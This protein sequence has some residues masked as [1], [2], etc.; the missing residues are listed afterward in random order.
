[1]KSLLVVVPSLFIS[2]V[3]LAAPHVDAQGN[4]IRDENSCGTTRVRVANDQAPVPYH[5][6]PRVIYLNKNGGTYNVVNSAT[7]S[8]TNTASTITS[9]DGAQHM[10]A[11]IPPIEA[12]YNWPYIVDCVKKQYKPYNVIITETE[13]TSGN[14]IEAVVGGNGRSTGWSSSSGI[15]GVASADNFCG[16]TEKGIA[17]SFSTNHLGITKPND[18]LCATIAHEVGH[19]VALEHEISGPD[20][21][22][23]VSFAQAGSKSFT[24]AD[25]HCGTD[26]SNQISCSC[27]P[28]APGNL[29]SSGKRLTMF[30]GARP[31]ETVPPTL[32]VSDPT[33]NKTLR[34]KFSILATAMDETAMDQVA[35]RIDGAV[36]GASTT[37]TDGT[38]YTITLSNV[39]EGPHMLDVEAVDLAGN[40]TKKQLTITVAKGKPGEDCTA[41]EDCQGNLCAV[42]ED[43]DSFCTQ[44]CDA[45]NKCPSGFSCDEAAMFC[46]PSDGG[47]CSVGG[48]PAGFAIILGL[49]LVLVPRR[50]K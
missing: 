28:T 48:G 21:M 30:L 8:A 15:L 39:P 11:V 23:Y 19:L 24:S 49:M 6:A 22:S 4:L 33:N 29:T 36:M 31:M 43:G 47:G 50:R 26:N 14:Y 35:A 13:P 40:I 20:T 41:S 16:V 2:S 38:K 46:M 27:T 1:V 45:T 44:A 7:D 37:P 25:S 9:G 34:P 10:N 32:D 5:A 42:T 18:E 12:S 17:F 3:A